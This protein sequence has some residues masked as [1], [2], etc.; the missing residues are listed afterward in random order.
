MLRLVKYLGSIIMLPKNCCVPLVATQQPLPSYLVCSSSA[1]GLDVLELLCDVSRGRNKL[2]L[3]LH[4]WPSHPAPPY[5][6]RGQQRCPFQPPARATGLGEGCLQSL[7]GEGEMGSI[8]FS[9]IVGCY[10]GDQYADSDSPCW[11]IV[12]G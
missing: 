10:G 1:A 6:E 11:N 9:P 8:V 4:D 5:T 2:Q 3:E 12:K 7:C